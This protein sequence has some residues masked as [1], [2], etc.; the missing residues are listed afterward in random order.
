MRIIKI[1]SELKTGERFG[2]YEAF[3]YFAEPA[4][5]WTKVSDNL[6]KR[7]GNDPV[8]IENLEVIVLTEE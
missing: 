3:K 6:I 1:I 8:K 7:D 2:F 4:I 5:C